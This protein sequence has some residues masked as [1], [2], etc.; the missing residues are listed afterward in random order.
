[1]AMI[2]R[3]MTFWLVAWIVGIPLTLLAIITALYI[4][5][6]VMGPGPVN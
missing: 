2:S 5:T 3:Q 6:L 1:M 4:F